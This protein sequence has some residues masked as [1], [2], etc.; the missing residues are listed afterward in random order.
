MCDNDFHLPALPSDVPHPETLWTFGVVKAALS[1]GMDQTWA[2]FAHIAEDG[3]LFLDL[4]GN[5]WRLARFDCARFLLIGSNF[6]N[7]VDLRDIPL[8]LFAD[9]PAA[10]PWEWIA[11]IESVGGSDSRSSPFS[12]AYWWDG[13]RWARSNYPDSV[14]ADGVEDAIRG[15]CCSEQAAADLDELLRWMCADLPAVADGH[16][17]ELLATALERRVEQSHLA[18]F[19]DLSFDIAAVSETLRAGGILANSAVAVAPMPAGTS[20]PAHRLRVPRIDDRQW[21]QLVETAMHAAT[22]LGRPTPPDSDELRALLDSLRGTA[23]EHGGSITFIT[24]MG[25]ATTYDLRTADGTQ[26]IPEQ[27]VLTEAELPYG[28]AGHTGLHN[29]EGIP[30]APDP[31][32][33][34]HELRA[35][36]SHRRRGT[37]F[38]LR[39]RVTPTAIDIERVY[40]HFPEWTTGYLRCAVG[41]DV[42]ISEMR[43]RSNEWRPGW[44][45]LLDKKLRDN[46]PV[47]AF[48]RPAWAR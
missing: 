42:F 10:L 40:D 6:R 30:I 36:E 11:D 12:F 46:P 32:D 48:T 18:P 16:L 25:G 13:A 8:N 33:L 21:W 47:D 23:D 41:L 1:A 17:R 20:V 2:K 26:V 19:A 14:D 37:W 9:A 35:V 4:E 15:Y 27:R 31:T 5:W 24:C 3:S 22:D 45:W 43:R 28:T 38:L 39:I 34:A 7:T 29:A 44:T